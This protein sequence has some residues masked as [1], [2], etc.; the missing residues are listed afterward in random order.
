MIAAE[1]SAEH[2]SGYV[3][4]YDLS[5]RDVR[6][7]SKAIQR[8]AYPYLIGP[9][10]VLCAVGLVAGIPILVMTG[11]LLLIA[12]VLILW[13]GAR[14]IQRVFLKAKG[15]KSGESLRVRLNLTSNALLSEDQAII[16]QEAWH[17]FDNFVVT[18]DWL[19]I[20][21]SKTELVIVPRSQVKPQDVNAIRQH[22]IAAGV[23]QRARIS[24]PKLALVSVG[25]PLLF[26]GLLIILEA[27]AQPAS[28]QGDLSQLTRFCDQDEI[29]VVT[30]TADGGFS[31][32]CS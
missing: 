22:L 19:I 26:I 3:I 8:F 7:A 17:R 20:L 4:E 5:G 13:A 14:S 10:W 29:G 27:V 23:K 16:T 24:R 32:Y 30:E 21:N 1:P 25:I 15:I 11:L 28:T 6:S 18:D 12:M 31:F 9:P 2:G